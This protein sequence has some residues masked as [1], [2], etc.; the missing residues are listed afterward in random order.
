MESPVGRGKHACEAPIVVIRRLQQLG[1]LGLMQEAVARA[2]CHD[3]LVQDAGDNGVKRHGSRLR[4]PTS[5]A[6]HGGD[7]TVPRLLQPSQ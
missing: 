1:G 6:S 4:A 5:R 3:E 7:R 2:D